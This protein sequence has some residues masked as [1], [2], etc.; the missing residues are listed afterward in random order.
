MGLGSAQPLTE[1]DTRITS[2]GGEGKSGRWL[3]LTTLPTSCV[4]KKSEC[5]KFPRIIAACPVCNG[6]SLRLDFKYF[7]LTLNYNR[8]IGSNYVQI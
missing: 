8:V 2:R 1:M 4:V 6:I 3:G 7:L 5:G